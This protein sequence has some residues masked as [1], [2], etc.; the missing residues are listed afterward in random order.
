MTEEEWH[1][2][3]YPGKML[4]ELRAARRKQLSWFR[5]L[6][7]RPKLSHRKLQ[8][9]SVAWSRCFGTL[10]DDAARRLFNNAEN[11]ADRGE[12]RFDREDLQSFAD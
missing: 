11:Y 5:R 7:D 6:G 1:S 2:D 8:L 12:R 10:L 4:E 3:D 9:L